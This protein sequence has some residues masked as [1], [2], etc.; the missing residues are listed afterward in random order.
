LRHLQITE[1][2][3][4]GRLTVDLDAPR[5]E[6]ID[7]A[8]GIGRGAVIQLRNR[9]SVK[10]LHTGLFPL[11]L[12]PYPELR[13]LWINANARYYR[14]VLPSLRSQIGSCPQLEAIFYCR[15]QHM[16]MEDEQHLHHPYG[17][18][19]TAILD[20]VRETGRVITVRDFL[21]NELDLPGALRRNVGIPLTVI[22]LLS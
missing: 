11:D 20:L 1:N 2:G 10:Q 6:S 3:N 7:E 22:L 17:S 14:G 9:T 13:Q 19:F 15:P 8:Y 21:E 16:A 12:S 4:E 18:E 5:L